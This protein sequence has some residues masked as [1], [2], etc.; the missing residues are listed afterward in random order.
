MSEA[1]HSSSASVSSD[2]EPEYSIVVPEGDNL[3]VCCRQV[4][5]RADY[6]PF[7]ST[8]EQHHEGPSALRQAAADGC[9]ICHYLWMTM[10]RCLAK[11]DKDVSR[12]GYAE[13]DSFTKYGITN[14]SEAAPVDASVISYDMKDGKDLI[15]WRPG[16]GLLPTHVPDQFGRWS[17]YLCREA[18]GNQLLLT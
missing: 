4:F 8:N 13:G 14:S 11:C 6:P 1:S 17:V 2:D 9:F 5:D 18:I 10:Q 3:C 16:R 12:F 15:E 7:F